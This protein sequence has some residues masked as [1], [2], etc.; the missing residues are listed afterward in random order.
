MPEVRVKGAMERP[1]Q[2]RAQFPG[3]IGEREIVSLAC[4]TGP[5]RGESPSQ[6]GPGEWGEGLRKI[7]LAIIRLRLIKNRAPGGGKLWEGGEKILHE[8]VIDEGKLGLNCHR[9]KC[10]REKGRG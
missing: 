1:W 5:G 4:G 9:E 2:K 6:G 10:A 7:L 8:T 3:F